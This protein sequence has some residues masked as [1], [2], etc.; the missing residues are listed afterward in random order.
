MADSKQSIIDQ[1]TQASR[2]AELLALSRALGDAS[3][4]LCILGEG[5]TSVAVDKAHLAVKASGSVLERLREEDV[6]LCRRAPLLSALEDRALTDEQLKAL[7]DSVKVNSSSKKPSIETIFHAWLL[8]LPGVNYVGHTHSLEAN[9]ILCSPRARDFAE[10]RLFPDEIVFCG[11]ASVFVPYTDPGLPLAREIRDRVNAF[12]KQEDAVPKLVL[13]Q[14]HGIIAMGT[15]P[16]AVMA[17][18]LM[19]DKAAAV[20]SGAA[21]MGGPNFLTQKHVERIATRP[22]EHE[23]QK[24]LN[25]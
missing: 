6:T 14:N 24:R 4:N 3:R 11:T 2:V 16:D 23:R 7:L 9:K 12:I 13:L 8:C 5:N 21:A 10:R 20:F 19:A 17:C 22:D 18:T 1:E 25:T 15:T